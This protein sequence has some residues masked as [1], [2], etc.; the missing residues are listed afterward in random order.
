MLEQPESAAPAP[1]GPIDAYRIGWSVLTGRP[2]ELLLVAVVWAAVS[3]PAA[4]FGEGVLGYGYHVFVL[5]PVNFG[6][7]YAFLRAARGAP[8]EVNDL[9][10]PFRENYLQAVLASLLV[11]LTVM[12]GLFLLIVPGILALVRLAWVPYLV[13]D[14]RRPALEAIRES[15]NGTGAY[16]WT[17]LGI[18]VLAIPV[19]LFG[20]FL[21]VVGVLPAL[22][23]A[24]LA[25]ASFYAA[26]APRDEPAAVGVM[27]DR[28]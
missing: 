6:G 16:A 9:L 2:L 11:S 21:F 10:T 8:P 28:P 22:V 7:M 14:G 4:I 20:I 3:I 23:L 25:A 5:G 12:I 19:I 17:I 13:V 18:E 27:E 24:Q 1:P 15:W 26:V